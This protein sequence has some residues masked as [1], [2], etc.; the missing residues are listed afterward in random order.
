[1]KEEKILEKNGMGV[2]IDRK[3]QILENIGVSV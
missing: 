3:I 1:M 2:Q